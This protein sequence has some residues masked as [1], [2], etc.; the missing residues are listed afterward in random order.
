[1]R[2]VEKGGRSFKSTLVN[3]NPGRS[4]G[5]TKSDCFSCKDNKGEGGD[6]RAKNVGY[7]IVCEDCSGDKTVTYHGETSKNTYVRGKKHLENYK[8]K[9]P[10]S[11]LYKHAQSDH[12]G[13][14]NVNYSMKVK[15]K[16][17][18]TLTRQVNEGVRI[19][20]CQAEVSLNSK[21]EWHG[22]ATVRLVIDE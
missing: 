10:N 3:T 13:S 2:V 16:F 17:R 20:R 7:E 4:T 5:C 6:C 15:S 1:M 14:M 19:S 21:S 8:Y 11:A 18:D 12:Q 22:P 9:L